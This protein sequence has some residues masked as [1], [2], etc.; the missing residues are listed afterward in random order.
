MPRK[1]NKAQEALTDSREGVMSQQ[2]VPKKK[3]DEPEVVTRPTALDFKKTE[4]LKELILQ[5]VSRNRTQSFTQYTKSLIKQYMT[6][7]VSYRQQIIGVSRFL[8]R[9]SALYRKIIM[10]YATMPMYHYNITMKMDFIKEADETKILK[11]YESTLKILQKFNFK[12]EFAVAIALAIRDGVYFGFVYN[13]QEDGSFLHML[14]VE[15]CKIRGKNEAGQWI[16]S[17]DMN[18]FNIGQNKIFVEGINGDTSGCWHQCFQDAWKEYNADRQNNRWFIIPSEYTITLLAGLGDDEFEAPLPPLMSVWTSLLD[19]LDFEQMI[20]DREEAYNWFLIML[21]VP[22]FD[23]DVVD[24]F[25]VSLEIANAYKEALENIAPPSVGIGLLPGLE[26]SEISFGKSTTADDTDIL[27]RTYSNIFKQAGVAEHIVSTGS[28]TSNYTTQMAINN[29]ASYAF[30]LVSRLE[31]NYQYWIDKNIGDGYLFN[32]L[33]QTH[34][35]NKDYIEQIR[36]ASTLGGSALYF[37]EAQGMTPYEAMNQLKFETAIG[38]KTMMEP[39]ES[40][41][42][43]TADAND[44]RAGRPLSDSGDLSDSAERTRNTGSNIDE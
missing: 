12:N 40:S 27:Q 3:K 41:Y 24:D 42:N 21:K 23:N 28:S 10:Y 37:L 8:Y 43:R 18:Y 7:P 33:R 5:D 44:K 19:A 1:N 20:A 30:L 26:N 6:N 17:F 2:L 36:V 11:G 31:S 13:N 14:P 32:I 39:L 25:S 35:N 34:Y 15:Y 4:K 29:D 16:I 22:T 9:S 38:I